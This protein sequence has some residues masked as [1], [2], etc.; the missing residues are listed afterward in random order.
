MHEEDRSRDTVPTACLTLD[1]MIL[2]EQRSPPFF[3][4]RE[5][6]DVDV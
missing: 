1:R 3:W 2:S 4:D 5:E 6:E